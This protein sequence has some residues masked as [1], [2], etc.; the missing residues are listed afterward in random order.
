MRLPIL[1]RDVYSGFALIC[2]G[3]VTLGIG[4]TYPIGTVGSMGPG[5]MPV[6]LSVVLLG[7]GALML[8]VGLLSNTEKLRPE[9]HLPDKRGS[10]CIIGSLLAFI[11]LA[12]FTGLVPASV[13]LVFISAMG[14]RTQTI[15]SALVLTA[16]VTAVGI[17]IL[18]FGLGLPFPLF[19]WG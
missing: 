8:I 19:T 15:K 1:S 16:V 4:S 9:W 10:I 14:D 5:F 6:C 12:E 11:I 13:A 17:G 7:V 18:S 3:L 2:F